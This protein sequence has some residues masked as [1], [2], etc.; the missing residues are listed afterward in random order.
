VVF[1][2]TINAAKLA[3][4]ALIIFGVATLGRGGAK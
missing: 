4:V 2:E 1:H 3:G